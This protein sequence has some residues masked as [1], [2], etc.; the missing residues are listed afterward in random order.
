M[1]YDHNVD[2][3]IMQTTD[4]DIYVPNETT[5]AAI[6]EAQDIAEGRVEAKVYHSVHEML[7][8]ILDDEERSGTRLRYRI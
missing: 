2:G 6:K 8:D 4:D 3:D 7:S 5:I 1:T